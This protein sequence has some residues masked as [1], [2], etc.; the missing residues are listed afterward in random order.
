MASY[1]DDQRKAAR[2]LYEQ[3]GPKAAAEQLHIPP[4]T[5]RDWAKS[6]GWGNRLAA[7]SS[8]PEHGKAVR[9]GWAIRK[10]AL[11]DEAG[12]AAAEALTFLRERIRS[13]KVYGVFELS[14]A[15]SLLTERAAEMSTG[16]GGADAPTLTPE[17]A[18][19]RIYTVLDV[20]E[21]RA[22]GGEPDG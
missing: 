7:V 13:R 17:Q 16:L 20:I 9:L 12:E 14:R 5:I 18:V 6:E 8:G 4:R 22:A 10:Q 19:A 21:P 15:F 2:T 1:T 3:R 11:A